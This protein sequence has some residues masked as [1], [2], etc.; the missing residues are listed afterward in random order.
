MKRVSANARRDEMRRES[1]RTPATRLQVQ[2]PPTSPFNCPT[3][4]YLFSLPGRLSGV[5][6][7]VVRLLA[8]PPSETVALRWLRQAAV[9]SD[10]AKRLVLVYVAVVRRRES[11][12]LPTIIPHRMQAHAKSLV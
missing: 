5:V 8:C 10:W 12:S 11:I 2:F 3:P 1:A 6:V 7:G 9:A 4:T